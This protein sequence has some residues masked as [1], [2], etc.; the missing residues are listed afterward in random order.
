M[1]TKKEQKDAE[2]SALFSAYEQE[3]PPQQVTDAAK[4]ELQRAAVRVT[5]AQPVAAGAGGTGTVPAESSPRTVVLL[6]A[7]AALLVLFVGLFLWLRT[8]TG[9]QIMSNT[10]SETDVATS[11]RTFDA[12]APLP[13]IEEEDVLQFT[14][15]TLREDTGNYGAGDAIA[16]YAA[17]DASTMQAQV[18]AEVYDVDLDAAGFTEDYN[19]SESVEIGQIKFYVRTIEG[20]SAVYFARGNYKYNLRLESTDGKTVRD[21]LDVI[22]ESLRRAGY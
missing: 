12:Q 15:Y 22:A 8:P 6:C 14:V 19:E 7:C 3:M 16:W 11:E 10:L 17:Y 18:F 5:E 1:K 2:L 20:D 4:A 21:H 9:T 13:W